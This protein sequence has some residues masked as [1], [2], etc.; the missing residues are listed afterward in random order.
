MTTTRATLALMFL[1]L[2]VIPTLPKVRSYLP[3]FSHS[4]S[5]FFCISLDD[6][7]ILYARLPGRVEGGD[8]FS[9][10]GAVLQLCERAPEV[11]FLDKPTFRRLA[12]VRSSGAF[13]FFFLE[14]TPRF[15]NI[16]MSIA[17]VKTR[18]RIQRT[19]CSTRL[20]SDLELSACR[21]IEGRPTALA[22]TSA[23]GDPSGLS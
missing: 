1:R 13:C 8:R 23:L 19:A 14:L 3:E 4:G 17:M 20:M 9:A 15:H 5:Q 7:H 11:A 12:P 2:K 21:K 16:S 10:Y 6:Y 22:S 18:S